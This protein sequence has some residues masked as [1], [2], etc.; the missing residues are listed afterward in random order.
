MSFDEA[1]TVFADPLARIFDD[2][3]HSGDEQREI[4]IGHSAR[5]R[6]LVVCFSARKDTVRIFSAAGPRSGSGETMKRTSHRKR[7]RPVAGDIRAEYHFDY[8]KARPNR[9]AARMKGRT[10]AVV[11]DPD[12]ASLFQ[13]SE[14][15]NSLLRS[16]I[17]ALPEDVKRESKAG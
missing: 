16:V 11:L 6:L 17:S 12:V 7:R 4:I 8:R 5:F 13:T 1:L 14:A 9:F 15:V 3:D 10:V 2:E